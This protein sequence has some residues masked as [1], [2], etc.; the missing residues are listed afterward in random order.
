[1]EFQEASFQRKTT[2]IQ[3]IKREPTTLSSC[4]KVYNNKKK[5]AVGD[6]S[7]NKPNVS[8]FFMKN[9]YLKT[10]AFTVQKL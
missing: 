1:M 9:Q 10:L 6:N 2:T 3:L 5:S 8:Y 7:G 4:K